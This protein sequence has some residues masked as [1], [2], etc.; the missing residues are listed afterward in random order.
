MYAQSP[1]QNA[2]LEK[3]NG[4]LPHKFKELKTG[5]TLEAVRDRE[6]VKIYML[7]DDIEQY[8]RI[9]VER[10]GD[11]MQNSYSQCKE[12]EIDKGKFKNNYVEVTDQYPLSTKMSNQYRIKTVT[13]EGIV[14]I[15]PPISIAVIAE[16]SSSR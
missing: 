11:E 14:R 13:Y 5:A 3:I 9:F 16:A 7:I 10:G 2:Y 6:V 1:V 12:I 8:D 15:F 4:Q